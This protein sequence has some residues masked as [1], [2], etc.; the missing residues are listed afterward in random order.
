MPWICK[1]CGEEVFEVDKIF[2]HIRPDTILRGEYCDFAGSQH[3]ECLSGH[4]CDICELEE[5]A[6]WLEDNNVDTQ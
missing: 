2:Y 6:D 4:K 5:F 3:F 1:I